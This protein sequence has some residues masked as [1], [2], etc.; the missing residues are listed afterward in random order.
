M[1]VYR[2]EDAV[3]YAREWAFRR[4]PRYLD[5]ELLGDRKSVV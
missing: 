4:T 3:A 1:P 2:R 5:F